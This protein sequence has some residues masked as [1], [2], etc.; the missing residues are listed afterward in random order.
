[1]ARL[2]PAAAG[3][4]ALQLFARRAAVRPRGRVRVS[5]ADAAVE[6]RAVVP[7]ALPHG[8]CPLATAFFERRA[9]TG[10]EPLA[11]LESQVRSG[12]ST[13]QAHRPCAAGARRESRGSALKHLAAP[14]APTP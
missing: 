6:P 9:A 13:W 4:P 12:T 7:L 2:R 11:Y 8:S 3:V 1:M 14:I 10:T 5:V